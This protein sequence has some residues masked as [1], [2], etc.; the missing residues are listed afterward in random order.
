MSRRILFI[1]FLFS[2]TINA[3]SQ[4]NL[5]QANRPL[6]AGE[7][8][9]RVLDFNYQEPIE[10]VNIILFNAGD[11]TQV[12]GTITNPEGIFRLTNVKPGHYY[13]KLLFIGYDVKVID[14][15]KI[16]KRM[17]STRIG[18]ILL[19]Q[20]AIAMQDVEVSAEREPISYQIDKKVINVARHYTATTGTAVDVLENVPSVSVD[21]EGN[22]SLRGSGSFMVLIDG[23]PS[24]LE[25]NDALQQI[26]ASSIEN[27]E[28][29]TNPSAK[30]DPD[31]TAGI[32][33]IILKKN[34]LNG[35]NGIVNLKTGLEEKYGADF[36]LNFRNEKIHTSIG[37]NYDNRFYPGTGRSRN[38]TTQDGLNSYIHSD[39][40][41][42]RGRKGYG[43]RGTLD[44]HISPRDVLGFVLSFG[45]R[46]SERDANQDYDEWADPDGI[47]YYYLSRSASE[48]SGIRYRANMNFQHKFAKKG[49]ELT[50]EFTFS[51]RESEEEATNERYASFGELTSGRKSTEDGPG[52]W[53]RFKIDYVLP[54]NDKNKFEA[55]GQARLGRSNE[56]TGLSDFNPA[57]GIYEYLPQ[58]GH[59]IDYARDIHSLY[60]IYS[61]KRDKLGYQFG[62][63]GEYTY[64][65]VELT[66]E[67]QVF[68]IDR[69]DY[70]PT[71]HTSYKITDKQQTMASYT[72]RIDRPR[73]WYLEPFETWM[74]AYNVRTGNP[75]L[76]PEYIDSYEMGYQTFLGPNMFSVEAYYRVTQNKIERVR[77]V[78]ADNITLHSTE[79]VGKDYAFGTEFML[80][81]DLFKWWT[82]NTMANL[83]QYK[84]EGILL[85]QDFSQESFSWS[86]RFNN[87][88]KITPTIR[89]QLNNIY[90]SERVSSQGSRAGY[91][92][93]NLAL[94]KEFF[95][96]SFVVTLQINDIFKTAKYESISEGAD[97]Y[98][99]RYFKREAPIVMLNLSYNI[100]NYKPERRRQGRDDNGGGE[101][102]F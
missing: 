48:R 42:T 39:G 96:R 64:R 68:T 45:G 46:A 25:P 67:D 81:L 52:T 27:I 28:I 4:R 90:N 29:I 19:Q 44:Y 37:A 79:N 54:L 16:T 55:G 71:F 14:D 100:N 66:G 72:R 75:A 13:L 12:T 97:F 9:G 53:G 40:S 86:T 1:L 74:D 32:L 78:Y 38:E 47:H 35:N 11:S 85:G 95:Q 69:W 84:V 56:D 59:S 8:S 26:P 49:H 82:L 70:F 22:V 30:Y 101:E 77:S 15:I 43:I 92:A 23:R 80:N 57:S 65:T 17:P 51:R 83:Y 88:F 36:L 61:G 58:Y 20:S 73:S 98:N 102:E 31:G 89:V 24:V 2:L 94:R 7:I 10:Y 6:D 62:L 93:T 41:Y 3:F 21:I 33:N 63:R 60:S 87:S 34:S 99:Y 91:F 76:K 5:R 50:S 18:K